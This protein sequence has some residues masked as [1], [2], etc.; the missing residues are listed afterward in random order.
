M[1]TY[2][3]SA[4]GPMR[5]V[6]LTQEQRDTSLGLHVTNKISESGHAIATYDLQT[7]GHMHLDHAAGEGQIK[8]N[9]DVGRGHEALVSG[10][11]A[12]SGLIEREYGTFHSLPIECSC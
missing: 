5:Q 7:C 10:K 3:S 12:K 8:L 4:C 11:E 9:N 6:N 1:A 2:L